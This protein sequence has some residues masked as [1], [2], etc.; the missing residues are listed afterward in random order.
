V[1]LE[2]HGWAAKDQIVEIVWF[3]ILKISSVNTFKQDSTRRLQ[4][5]DRVSSAQLS[6]MKQKTGAF[7]GSRGHGALNTRSPCAMRGQK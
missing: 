7:S 5:P 4:L 1:L 2:L 6:G 3:E